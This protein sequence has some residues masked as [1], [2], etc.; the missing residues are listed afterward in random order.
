MLICLIR[1]LS[2]TACEVMAS[3][4]AGMLLH[5][6]DCRVLPQLC[7]LLC[8]GAG[9]HEDECLARLEAAD[10]GEDGVRMPPPAC[11]H[12]ESISH[13]SFIIDPKPAHRCT[14]GH[15]VVKATSQSPG[16]GCARPR[17]DTGLWCFCC[18]TVLPPL[19]RLSGRPRAATPGG[20][21]KGAQLAS[22]AMLRLPCG[23]GSCSGGPSAWDARSACRC[24]AGI[25]MA[26]GCR[27]SSCMAFSRIAWLLLR[28]LPP[29]APANSAS[30]RPCSSG[31]GCTVSCC[32][33]VSVLSGSAS[34]EETSDEASD[35]SNDPADA[36]SALLASELLDSA[37]SPAC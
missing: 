17:T 27:C 11:R 22:A 29:P 10:K 23:D 4:P 34:S 33:G 16:P 31:A 1:P 35:D 13:T 12:S 18:E 2:H 36:L 3:S 28:P 20:G 37:S 26:G 32:A 7:Q 6:G 24:D 9:H 8:R 30:R 19:C 25:C 21:C 15:H 5:Q 14:S